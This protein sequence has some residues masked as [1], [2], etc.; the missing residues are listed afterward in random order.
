M[1]KTKTFFLFTGKFNTHTVSSIQNNSQSESSHGTTESHSSASHY[2][3]TLQPEVS[4]SNNCQLDHTE[5]FLVEQIPTINA[6]TF[7]QS[8]DQSPVSSDIHLNTELSTEENSGQ[9][10]SLGSRLKPPNILVYCGIKD[11]A[12]KFSEVK[13]SLEACINTE[14]YTIYHLKHDAVLSAP[15]RSNS[16]LLLV[17]SCANLRPEVE[18]EIRNFVLKDHGKLLSFN[19][20]VESVFVDR[21]EE[22]GVNGERLIKFDFKDGQFITS[23]RGRFVYSG[24]KGNTQVI[25]PYNFCE[26]EN[27]LTEQKRKQ[28]ENTGAGSNSSSSVSDRALV[29]KVYCEG[30]GIT[31]LSQVCLIY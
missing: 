15:W 28:G 23:V 9:N 31:V 7:R 3:S 2:T 30:G 8:P 16:A 24:L 12:R 6:K 4:F 1:T 18:D 21:V 26:L 11:T 10:G 20:S 25:V 22:E 17:S 19:S 14:A 27:N 13:S 5:T 29:V